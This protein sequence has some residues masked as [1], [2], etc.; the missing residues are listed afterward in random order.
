MPLMFTL[1]QPTST[2]AWFWTILADML[3]TLL[4]DACEQRLA[5]ATSAIRRHESLMHTAITLDKSGSPTD[6]LHQE[7]KTNL[8]ATFDD[9]Q[10]A[11]DAYRE[12]LIEH[13]LIPAA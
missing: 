6:E 5:R 12:H 8:R 7:Y 2:M 10:S 9:A 3:A 4:C 1:R 13:G 11:W